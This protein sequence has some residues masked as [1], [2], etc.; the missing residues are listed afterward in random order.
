MRR[1][2]FGTCQISIC[3]CSI[4]IQGLCGSIEPDWECQARA[5]LPD[6]EALPATIL[7]HDGGPLVVYVGIEVVGKSNWFII[8]G[9]VSI[10]ITV[11]LC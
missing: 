8:I 3:E 10:A 9:V 4:P 7:K 5:L 2:P 1:I 11:N 6:G